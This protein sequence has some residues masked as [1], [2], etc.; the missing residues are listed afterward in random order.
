M[1]CHHETWSIIRT[2]SITDMLSSILLFISVDLLFVTYL[3][4]WY[5][6]RI[7]EIFFL[8]FSIRQ[9]RL[10]LHYSHAWLQVIVYNVI[11]WFE[12]RC[13]LSII[14]PHFYLYRFISCGLMISPSLPSCIV[15][16]QEFDLHNANILHTYDNCFTLV[17]IASYFVS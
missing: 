12:F 2:T 6:N 9:Y 15:L 10:F 13:Q 1:A 17:L 7:Y 5:V 16:T 4:I 11:F 14:N 8:I 3:K